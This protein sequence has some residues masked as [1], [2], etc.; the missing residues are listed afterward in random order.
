M[1]FFSTGK[2]KGNRG[3][4]NGL[5]TGLLA[6]YKCDASSGDLVD[7]HTNGYDCT[8][9]GGVGTATGKLNDARDFDPAS[10]EYFSRS[11]TFLPTG[12]D[13]RSF[14]FWMY[15]RDDLDAK[16][17][18]Y[19]TGSAGEDFSW[20]PEGNGLRWRHGGGNITWTTNGLNAWTHAVIVVP[21]T[22]TTTDDILVYIDGSISTGSRTAGSNRT[23]DTGSSDFLYGRKATESTYDGLLDEMTIH[24][25]ALTASQAS[26][27]YGGGTPPGYSAFD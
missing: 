3:G 21:S 11:G 25:V 2:A 7:A 23:L 18:S 12:A 26:F 17:F 13:E 15:P 5:L 19:G 22:A 14:S 9:N 16:I 24:D 6:Y 27:L 20:T 1:R 8:D 10:T 4:G